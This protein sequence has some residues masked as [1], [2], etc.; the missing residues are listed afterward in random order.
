MPKH[1]EKQW[2]TWHAVVYIP[3]DVQ[4]YF[5]GKTRFSQTLQTD[6]LSEAEIKKLPLVAEWKELIK[7]AR[8]A[9]G[10]VNVED[11]AAQVR[12]LRDE[13]R[14]KWQGHEGDAML[15]LATN[16][17]D[18]PD[19]DHADELFAR[20]TGEWNPTADYIM[21][22][23]EHAEYQPKTA[24]EARTNVQQF[25]DEFR[26]FEKVTRKDLEG[27]VEGLLKER[28][29]PTVKKKVGHVR[30]YWAYCHKKEYTKATPPPEGLVP[31]PRKNKATATAAMMRKRRHWTVED[32]QRLIVA[33]PEDTQLVDLIKL[34]AHTGCRLEEIC[35]MPV[36][37]VKD[38][39]FIVQ[40]AKTEAGWREIPIHSDIKQ[41]VARLVDEST[42]GF[43]LS[44]LS[45]ENKYSKRGAAIGKR[46]GRL[47]TA[48]G[49]P[50]TLVF[51]SFR[52]T[53]LFLMRDRGIPEPQ[54]ALIVGHEP[55]TITYGLYGN[56]ISFGRKVEIMES[57]SY[58]PSAMG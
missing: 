40:D 6:S 13:I 15:E 30:A 18:H 35:S 1:L 19:Q 10:P 42:D 11:I 47:R 36:A 28:S 56:D 46:F 32:Y 25:C 16:L 48:L 54:A 49:Y 44:G 3:K 20:V 2:N 8:K 5:S 58:R 12:L 31:K 22:W 39:R 55:N 27:W 29:I 7:A 43:L 33:K 52:K 21:E 45:S 26:I 9:R 14:R 37:N 53:L 24:D 34:G 51:H 23:L 41:T 38:D 50:D 4:P 17:R 57:I